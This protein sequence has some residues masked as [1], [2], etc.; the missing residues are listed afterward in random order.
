[1]KITAQ[2]LFNIVRD[3][4][5][6]EIGFLDDIINSIDEGSM[7]YEYDIDILLYSRE[8]GDVFI[9]H[10]DCLTYMVNDDRWDDNFLS[11]FNDEEFDMKPA[12]AINIV[13]YV[14]EE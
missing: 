11:E 5:D 12:K 1:M 2:R 8:N 7:S 9:V 4:F 14:T 13:K 10:F 3:E 6:E